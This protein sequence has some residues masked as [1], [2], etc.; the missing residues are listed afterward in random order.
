M[1]LI[2]AP[3]LHDTAGAAKKKKSDNQMDQIKNYLKMM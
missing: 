3:E 1:G 2:L